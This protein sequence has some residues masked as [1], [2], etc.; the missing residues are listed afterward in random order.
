MKRREFIKISL[1]MSAGLG[2][3]CC[4]G[5]GDEKIKVVVLGFDGANWPTIDPLIEKGRLPFLK[6]LK[7]ESAWANFETFKPAKSNVVWT[8]IA[9]G[10]TMLKHGILDFAY[11]K[12]NNIKVPFSKSDRREPM[13]WQILDEC[14]KRCGV[15]NWWCSHPP[16]KIN[17]VMVS[18]NFR[19]MVTSKPAML[20]KFVNSVHPITFYKKFK[21]FVKLNNDYQEVIKRT[22]LP[23]FD[24]LF[25]G[26]YPG[27]D[28]K[29]VPVIK[30]YR[31]YARHDAYIE[32]ISRYLLKNEEFDFF[33]TYFRLPDVCQHFI[34]LFLDQGY[35]ENLKKHLIAETLTRQMNDEAIMKISQILEPVYRYMEKIIRDYMEIEKGKNTYFFIMSDH[36]FSFFKGGYNH[37]GLPGNMKAPDGILLISG[38]QVRKGMIKKA[39]VFDVAPS[40]L[41][42]L[43]LAVDRNMDG[44]VLSE[45]FRFHRPKRYKIYKLKLEKTGKRDREYD[46]ETMKDLKSLGYI[47]E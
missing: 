4:G 5:K 20:P 7:E 25:K 19:R 18:D 34:T 29:K 45:I 43:D 6:K 31:D 32:A 47:N 9:S 14:E 24:G 17:G 21:E 23:D 22:G 10:K 40:I 16:D 36:G 13:I 11:L 26:L 46:R 44:R 12:K 39:G 1:L 15:L 38:P 37:Y 30:S 8:S 35:K 28:I 3:A 33:A 27:L 2:P 42:L 41:N